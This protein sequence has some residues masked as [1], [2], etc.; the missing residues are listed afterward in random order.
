MTTHILNTANDLRGTLVRLDHGEPVVRYFGDHTEYLPGW[1]TLDVI[2]SA[3]YSLTPG[4]FEDELWVDGVGD[5]W[6][7][8]VVPSAWPCEDGAAH[9]VAKGSPLCWFC[10][11]DSRDWEDVEFFV[12]VS[13]EGYPADCPARPQ[14]RDDVEEW[15]GALLLV[16]TPEALARSAGQRAAAPAPGEGCGPLGLAVV[17]LSALV[18]L[19]VVVAAVHAIV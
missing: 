13:A 9:A 6:R 11:A 19:L 12:L 15:C 7:R 10:G 8:K 14:L 16:G 18:A 3:E 2:S 4:R 5:C 1:R 17:V